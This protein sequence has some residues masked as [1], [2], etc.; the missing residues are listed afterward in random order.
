MTI[1]EFILAIE[2]VLK[3][4]IDIVREILKEGDGQ[5][6]TKCFIKILYKTK[7]N[8]VVYVQ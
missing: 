3:F 2:S 5:V 8:I 4:K 1:G 7:K 6:D